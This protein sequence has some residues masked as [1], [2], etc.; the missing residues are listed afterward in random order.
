MGPHSQSPA[1]PHPSRLHRGIGGLEF[2][3]VNRREHLG[4]GHL[5]LE[6]QVEE[7][8]PLE[9]ALFG[10][11]LSV[12]VRETSQAHPQRRIVPLQVFPLDQRVHLGVTAFGNG[13]GHQ[14]ARVR[15]EVFHED[16]LG[17][18]RAKVQQ[19][20]V[21]GKGRRVNVDRAVPPLIRRGRS[22][23]RF[24]IEFQVGSLADP[25]EAQNRTGGGSHPQHRADI[26]FVGSGTTARRPG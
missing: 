25:L 19:V 4:N 23:G 7:V 18:S 26:L 15:V 11:N 14:P 21:G 10:R 16:E 17:K 12:Q 5:V 24:Q 20:R 8:E 3:P 1:R 2:H 6:I 13:S 9:V 22:P